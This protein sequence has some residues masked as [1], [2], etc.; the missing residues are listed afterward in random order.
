M[1]RTTIA[2]AAASLLVF[3]HG[4]VKAADGSADANADEFDSRVAPILATHCRKCHGAAKP[5]SGLDLTSAGTLLRGGDSGPAVVPGSSTKSLL[6]EQIADGSMPPE[7]EDRLSPDELAAI[8]HWIDAGAHAATAVPTQTRPP[9]DAAAREYW[10]FRKLTPPAVPQ[11]SAAAPRTPVDAFIVARLAG[12]RL[13]LAPPADRLTLL[14]RVS[15]DLTG[16]PPTPEEIEAFAA[17]DRDDSYERLVDR[18]LASPAFGQRWGRHWLDAAGYS[19]ITGGDNDAGIIKLSDG[20]WK[21]RDYVVRSFNA[22]KPYDQFL[23]EQLAGDELVDWRQ[24]ASFSPETQELLVATGFLRNAADDTDEKELTTPD[25]LHGVLQRT[26][27]VVANNLLGLTVGCAKCHDHKYEPISQQEYYRLVAAFS[28][29]FN[30]QSWVPPKSRALA[31]ISPKQRAEAERHN[32]ELDRQVAELRKSQA[33][34]RAPVRATL[35]AARLAAIP[36]P[37]RDDVKTAVGTEAAKRTE[38]QKYLAEKFQ[39]SLN[40]SD[41]DVEAALSE[42]Q[43][44][45][46]AQADGQIAQRRR[47]KA[48]LGHDPGSLRSRTAAGNAPAAPRQS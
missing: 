41:A 47:A 24:S 27:E 18:L 15:L 44:S 22:D 32:A 11:V 10:A 26:S 8:R 21:Y 28:P 38:V 16:L 31:D 30:P 35:A 2:L 3:G 1:N 25:I 39:A 42:E 40:V 36:E 46:I 12:Q 34:V 33:D 9:S 20:K 37:I 13:H 29:T 48:H 5:K 45:A 7:G 19:D 43:K 4:A 6:V 23:I 17:D 14:R